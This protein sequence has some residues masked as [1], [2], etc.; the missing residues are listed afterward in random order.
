VYCLEGPSQDYVQAHKWL[1]LAAS[2]Y[3]RDREFY[4]TKLNEIA[5]K[6]TPQQVA[7][8]QKLTREWKT[9]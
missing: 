7:E 6:M 5:A 2:A 4:R 3:S 8:A 9:M 1:S